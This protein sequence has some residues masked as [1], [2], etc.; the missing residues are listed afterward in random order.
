MLDTL[1]ESPVAVAALG[2]NLAPAT[3][4]LFQAI[5]LRQ[6]SSIRPA[7][8]I[9]CAGSSSSTP[10]M[11]TVRPTPKRLAGP[12]VLAERAPTYTRRSSTPRRL[13]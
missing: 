12:R 13:A 4:K 3:G 7:I 2:S 10:R 8:E 5:T 11:K 6:S 9:P 1:L